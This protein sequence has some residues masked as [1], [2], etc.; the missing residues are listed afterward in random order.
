MYLMTH[1]FHRHGQQRGTVF[2]SYNTC[3]ADGPLLRKF[4]C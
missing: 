1:V 4:A 3:S 2:T